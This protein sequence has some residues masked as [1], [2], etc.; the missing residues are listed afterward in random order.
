MQTDLE[1]TCTDAFYVLRLDLKDA[2]TPLPLPQFQYN[3]G[4]F[5]HSKTPE[6]EVF[7]PRNT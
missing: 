7:V 4:N 3:F 2:S 5:N 6:H 1:D